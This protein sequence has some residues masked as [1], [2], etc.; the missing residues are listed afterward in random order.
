MRFAEMIQSA[1]GKAAIARA[2]FLA[3]YYFPLF[4]LLAKRRER[5]PTTMLRIC[6]SARR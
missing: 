2:I 4:G 6:H 3:G 5:G 1:W